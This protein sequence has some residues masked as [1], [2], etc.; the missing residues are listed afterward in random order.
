[1]K[2]FS[3][4]RKPDWQS[5]DAGI[6]ADAVANDP[7]PA[8]LAR[9]PALALEDADAQ[10]R[11]QALRRCA[12]PALYAKA[13]R[14]E[15][16]PQVRAWARQQWL[17]AVG[18]GAVAAPDPASLDKAE[19]EQLAVAAGDPKL[20]AACLEHIQRPGFLAE[21]VLNET[22]AGLRQTL[23]NRID[24]I[25]L[26]E[27]TAGQLRRKDKRLYRLTRE[28]AQALR[29]ATGD[30]QARQDQGQALCEQME[31]LM[32]TPLATGEKS[33]QLDDY[34]QQW[35][36]MA[37]ETL[38]ELLQVRFQGLVDVIQAQ[39]QPAA[40]AVPAGVG[41]A[42]DTD[43]E[44]DAA[45]AP[46]IPS[47][48]EIAA[49][50][51]LEATLARNAAEI[52]RERE[53]TAQRELEERQQR[54]QQAQGLEQLA[55]S[56]E[57]GDLATSRAHLAQ[58]QPATFT[59]AALRHWQSLQPRL[60]ELQGWQSWAN[61][62][63][64]TRLCGEIERLVGSGLHPDAISH[65]IGEIRD[66]W[67][68]L[69]QLEGRDDDSPPTGLDRRLRAACARALKPAR[70]FF[71]KRQSLRD[72]LSQTVL[73]FLADSEKHPEL[74]DGDVDAA[75]ANADTGDAVV[76]NAADTANPTGQTGGQSAGQTADA[77]P[78]HVDPV[79]R[80]MALQKAA[81]GHLR[82]L[83]P[84]APHQRKRLAARLRGLL[85]AIKPRLEAAFEQAENARSAL[86]EAAGQLSQENDGR[87]LARQ[88][89][90][91]QERW[92]AIGMGRRSRDQQQ[93]RQFR[94]AIDQ[95]FS[96]LD[97]QRAEH[98][99]EQDQRRQEADDVVGELEQLA[100]LTGEALQAS[101]AAVR[102]RRERWQ[103]LAVADRA[104]ADRY[105]NALTRHRLAVQDLAR[106]RTRQQLHRLLD[107]APPT[108]AATSQPDILAQASSLVFEA[109]A[110]CDIA[111]P[112]DQREAR[113]RWQL[114]RLQ[115]HMSGELAAE[116]HDRQ[117]VLERLLGQWSA[118]SGLSDAD[119]QQLAARL[120]QVI[121]SL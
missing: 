77:Q 112:E 5:S 37:P 4:F 76:D 23:I 87:Q 36:Q 1:M 29:L 75:Q 34:R 71:D 82:N 35:Q 28:R 27:R 19:L 31:Q 117:A 9:L 67:R 32:R 80:L 58:L 103:K 40:E 99:A 16:D 65:R 42:V 38:P 52:A 63:V 91:L 66:Q 22:D 53:L 113:Q 21:R 54:Q 100:D 92:Q 25:E 85:D 45:P 24:D 118:L 51:Q 109:E 74:I 120:R 30:P 49:Q 11:R 26:L 70:E 69:D 96:R 44:S 62:K 6:R 116:A 3:A 59:G 48:E 73:A 88:A 98:Q 47:P 102:Q 20:R 90:Q 93:W 14:A 79:V 57:A 105:D 114:A 39:L 86:I 33:R 84:L 10:V 56:L 7:D 8:L 108:G 104:L 64:R 83:D 61:N 72:E 46:T 15:P 17:A 55:H 41:A 68:Q 13:M 50:V 121:D 119:H 78:A 110:L 2:L 107:S 101:A 43:G 115:A 12:D 111:A 81:I 89:R 94:A 95:A 60:R 18:T 106:E 97:Q